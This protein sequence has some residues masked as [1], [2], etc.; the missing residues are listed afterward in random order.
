MARMAEGGAM[1][2]GEVSRVS[3]REV[4]EGSRQESGGSPSGGGPIVTFHMGDTE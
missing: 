1:V 2:G 4:G 3:E